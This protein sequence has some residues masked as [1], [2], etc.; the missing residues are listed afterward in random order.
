VTE[1]RLCGRF[2]GTPGKLL[3]A[4]LLVEDRHDE[5]NQRI[6]RARQVLQD[7]ES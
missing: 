5:G 7:A 2:T 1:S 4:A 6:I 3:D